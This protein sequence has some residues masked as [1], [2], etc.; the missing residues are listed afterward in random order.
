MCYSMSM[1]VGNPSTEM[2]AQSSKAF[3][4]PESFICITFI[5]LLTRANMQRSTGSGSEL[6]TFF[7]RKWAM[8]IGYVSFIVSFFLLSFSFLLDSNYFWFEYV[9]ITCFKVTPPSIG[10]SSLYFIHCNFYNYLLK[11]FWATAL[12]STFSSKS[13][14]LIAKFVYFFCALSSCFS[15]RSSRTPD[16]SQKLF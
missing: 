13:S 16:A 1:S 2:L 15:L 14:G 5:S 10:A 7:G 8:H 11:S 6:D 12:S 4:V 3:L 9:F